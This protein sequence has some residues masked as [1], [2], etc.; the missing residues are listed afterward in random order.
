MNVPS[1]RFTIQRKTGTETREIEVAS[2]AGA[3]FSAR[4]V[5]AMRRELD[6]QIAAE[7]RYS[8]A[9]MTN[10][11]IFRIGRYLLTQDCEFEVQGAMTGGECEVVAVLMADE[12]LISVGSDQCDRE[13][14]PL[15]PDKPKQMCPHPVATTVWP[16]EEVAAHW[17]SLRVHSEVFCQGTSIVLQDAPLAELVALEHLLALDAVAKLPKPAFLYGGAAAFMPSAAEQIA[18]MGL[19]ETAAH[20]VGDS[21]LVRLTDPVLGRCI[22]H[23]FSPVPVGDDYDERKNRGESLTPHH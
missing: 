15:F 21:F 20:G 5:S 8:S 4:D 6:E 10:P 19:P 22:E 2:V 7:G 1:I 11:S 14:D 9:T 3:R 17:D 13:L 12:T 16:Y 23:Q 18:Q